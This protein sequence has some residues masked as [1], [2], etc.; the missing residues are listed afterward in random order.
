VSVRP[1]RAPLGDPNDARGFAVLIARY[2]ESLE[3]LGFSESTQ[4]NG[5]SYLHA[6]A[7]W[8][9]ERAVARPGEVT[10]PL[11]ERYQRWLFHY[12]QENGKPLSAVTQ[13]GMLQR[14][15]SFLAWL[16]KERYLL[17]NPASELELPKL[18]PRLPVDGFSLEEVETILATPDVATPIGIRDRALLETLYSTGIR[19]KEL[20]ALELYDVDFERGVLVVRKG[21]GGK[22]RVVPIGERALLWL[23]KYMDEVR[24]ELVGWVEEKALFVTGEGLRFSADGLGNRV[25]KVLEASG[26][27]RRPGGVCHLFR[28]TMAT[29]MLEGGADIR[30]IQEML[31]HARLETT[32]VYTRVSIAKLKEIH[33]ATHPARLGRRKGEE[34]GIE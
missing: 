22:A 13:Y 28:H 21:K 14:L 18:P 9:E 8:C 26:V 29:Q 2:L 15:K 6:F 31:G 25:K 23:R 17:Y 3:V 34:G 20:V 12:R 33:T 16:T 4:R 24:P 7:T 30:F 32:Q 19:R 10:R 1:S 27:R 5:R 11:V